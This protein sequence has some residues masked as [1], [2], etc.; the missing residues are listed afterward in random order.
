MSTQGCDRRTR[1]TRV[2]RARAGPSARRHHAR[3]SADA[4][5]PEPRGPHGDDGG[6]PIHSSPRLCGFA[7]VAACRFEKESG[8]GMRRESGAV[9]QRALRTPSSVLSHHRRAQCG[10][11]VGHGC[12]HTSEGDNRLAYR[13]NAFSDYLDNCSAGILRVPICNG[14]SL[15]A[16]FVL[17]SL[18]Y[19]LEIPMA[20]SPSSF[21]NMIAGTE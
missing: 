1:R 7:Q 10:A 13:E 2:S 20:S 15:Q 9:E 17:G 6:R 12:G 14:G 5:V 11:V 8:A 16:F 4:V 18:P 19:A 21:R 3:A